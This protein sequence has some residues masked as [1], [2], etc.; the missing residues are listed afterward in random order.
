MAAPWVAV[1]V[2]LQSLAW[3]LP[4]TVHLAKEKKKKRRGMKE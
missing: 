2:R 3:S 1:A 4:R